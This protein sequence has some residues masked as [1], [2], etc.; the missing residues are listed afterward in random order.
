[1]PTRAL[2]LLSLLVAGTALA[3]AD[4]T[5]LKIG[6]HVTGPVHAGRNLI[7]LPAGDWQVVAQSQDDITLSNNGSKRK[8]D[9]MRA[10]LLIKTDGKRLLATANLWGNLGQSS[11]EIKWSSTTCIKP[12]K[13]ILY[14]E[15]YGA[16]GGSNFF[17]CA[18]LNHWT[19]FLKGDS[20]Y[21]EQA[22][23]NIKALGLSLP[24]TTLNP[25][26]EDFYRGGIVKAYYNINPEALGFAPDATAEW[27]DSSWHL[28]N[29]DAKHRAL[30]D[31][32]TNW[33]IQMSAAML[34]ARTEGTLQTVP[35]L[36]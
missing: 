32:L 23:K 5:Q 8:T 27:K 19:G 31:K 21:Y 11:N 24:T 29:L 34:A 17:H 2:M 14:F 10:V 3:D 7:P 13:P 26:Y 4:I 1:M 33:T 35:D 16:S 9:E 30:T 36:P 28:D 25:S 6:D 20:A 15:N 18:K 12:D 22:R